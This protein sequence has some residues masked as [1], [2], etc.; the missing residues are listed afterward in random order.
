MERESN[1]VSPRPHE[2]RRVPCFRGLSATNPVT[3]GTQ[4]AKACSLPHVRSTRYALAVIYG[5]G[6][7]RSA[8]GS[9]ELN[10]SS[11]LPPRA[12]DASRERV[13]EAT[14]LVVAAAGAK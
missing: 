7:K 13:S 6:A 9:A 10:T 12:R 11:T 5:A 14:E 8:H 1:G 3:Q 2:P 4:A